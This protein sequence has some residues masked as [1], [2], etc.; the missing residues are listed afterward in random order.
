MDQVAPIEPSPAPASFRIT[1]VDSILII[2]LKQQ[3][4]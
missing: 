3:A 2:L 1:A 4:E